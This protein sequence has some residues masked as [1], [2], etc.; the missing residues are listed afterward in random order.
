METEKIMAD[1]SVVSANFNN[2]IFLNQFINSIF[3][4]T[5]L[6]KELIIV[7]DGSTDNSVEII[8]SLNNKLI[9]LI[10]LEKNIG[11]ANALNA[12]IKNAIG[13]YIMRVDPDDYIH[14]KRIELQYLYLESNPGIDI[15][16]TN[17]FYFNSNNNSIC[18]KTNFP[19]DFNLIRNRYYNG[20]H[21]LLHG[22]IMVRSTVLKNYYYNQDLVP[23]EDYDIF[24]R[25]I[26]DKHKAS[27]LKENLTYVRI[28]KTSISNNLQYSTIKKTFQ[29]N[30][31]LFN[32][33]VNS[34]YVY[35]Y[36]LH[37]KNYRKFLFSSTLFKYFYLIISIL[38][39][40]SKIWNRFILHDNR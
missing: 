24:A 39:M 4:S 11:F 14:E 12:G 19:Q 10:I 15:V 3:N 23:A 25:I 17:A 21:G 20:L 18:F 8:Q 7:D 40:P 29:I 31:I 9:K 37:M 28:H 1:V 26:K 36:Y 16:G 22:T 38:L 35:V 33:D 13:K 34:F 2:G 6:P 5:F 30:S 32:K 27:N